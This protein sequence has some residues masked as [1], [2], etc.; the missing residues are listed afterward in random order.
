M[1]VAAR[2]RQYQSGPAI[3]RTYQQR[4]HRIT[5]LIPT[6]MD[7]KLIAEARWSDIARQWSLKI[8]THEA[9][10]VTLAQGYEFPNIQQ[11]E[12]DDGH[13]RYSN[14][15]I[16]SERLKDYL[17]KMV[18]GIKMLTLE[19]NDRSRQPGKK[20]ISSFFA[21]VKLKYP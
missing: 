12:P 17:E 19:G 4:A 10:A 21:S 8:G 5:I 2:Y 14:E 11:M 9:D 18:G 20:S 1:S 6:D 7:Q 3:G 15:A 16:P 13:W